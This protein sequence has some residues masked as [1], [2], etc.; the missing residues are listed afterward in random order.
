[1]ASMQV[2]HF[3]VRAVGDGTAEEELNRFLRGHQ[4][5][6]VRQEF[7]ADGPNS[8]WCIAVR[9]ADGQETRAAGERSAGRGVDYKEILDPEAFERFAELRRRRKAIAEAEGLPVFAV[10]TNE[11]LAGIARLENPG[12][13]DLRTV[14]GIGAK[15]VERFGPRILGPAMEK[16]HE[17]GG[18]PV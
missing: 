12:P 11:E 6:E 15:K 1:M 2:R 10:F 4:V 16:D 5:L 7:V 13:D 18:T 14:K 17:A 9:Y 3:M 8:A